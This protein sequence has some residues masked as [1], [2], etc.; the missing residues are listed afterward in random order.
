MEKKQGDSGETLEY[1]MDESRGNIVWRSMVIKENDHFENG[2]E[3]DSSC[4]QVMNLFFHLHPLTHTNTNTN[5]HT[6]ARTHTHTHAHTHIHT[7]TNTH[8]HTR[9]RVRLLIFNNLMA[10][11]RKQDVSKATEPIIHTKDPIQTCD[12]RTRFFGR[13]E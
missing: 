10:T 13:D 3:K 2:N 11:E 8:T 4:L 1:D 7:H 5:A 9:A 6:R 12:P